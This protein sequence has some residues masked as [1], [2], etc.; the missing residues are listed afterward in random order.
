M[1]AAESSVAASGGLAV[2][3]AGAFSVVPGGLAVDVASEMSSGSSQR[4]ASPASL[5]VR[6]LLAAG[7]APAAAVV[8][9]SVLRALG[10]GPSSACLAA[11]LGL[12]AVCPP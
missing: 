7:A 12:A 11:F 4:C 8:E 5:A 6:A 1:E 2:E 9:V 3:A 10:G